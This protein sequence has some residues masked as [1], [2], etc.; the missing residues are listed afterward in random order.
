MNLL[1][2][3]VVRP[4]RTDQDYYSLLR[5]MNRLS[6]NNDTEAWPSSNNDILQCGESIDYLQEKKKLVYSGINT[7]DAHWSAVTST[8]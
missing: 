5:M 7:T 1:T 8:E 4:I 6:S 2:D 3:S